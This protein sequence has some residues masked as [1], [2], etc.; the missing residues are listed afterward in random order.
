VLKVYLGLL[1]DF[2]LRPFQP[3]AL[4]VDPEDIGKLSVLQRCKFSYSNISAQL[5]VGVTRQH[6][7]GL[8]VTVVLPTIEHYFKE[9]SHH[10]QHLEQNGFFDSQRAQYE[11]FTTRLNDFLLTADR[12]YITD[13]PTVLGIFAEQVV[14]LCNLLETASHP[15]HDTR[16]YSQR[17]A[18][19]LLSSL[20]D[21][22][23]TLDE[24]RTPYAH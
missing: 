19:P 1:K 16:S 22:S 21:I 14:T 2:L 13:I 24:M 20:I 12:R 3:T 5:F 15:D 4:P 9:V 6:G 18:G 10:I 11:S 8:D 23:A 7:K 17:V